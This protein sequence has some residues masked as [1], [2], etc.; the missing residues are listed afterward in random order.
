VTDKRV[1]M[2]WW[3]KAPAAKRDVAP[4]LYATWAKV[5]IHRTN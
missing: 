2:M 3:Y 4:Y 1:V 5:D